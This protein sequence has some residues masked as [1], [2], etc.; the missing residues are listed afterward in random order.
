MFISIIT[1]LFLGSVIGVITSISVYGFISLVKIL[2]NIF[3][4]SE[5]S[6]NGFYGLFEN[7]LEFILFV[8]ITPFLIGLIVGIIRKYASDSR[9][10]GPPDVILAVHSEKKLLD[11]KSGFLTSFS[12]ILS[13]SA[14]GSVGQYGPLVHFGATLGAEINDL[15]KR[16]G[17]YQIYVGAGVAAA[18]SSGFGAPLAGLIFAREVILRHQ[19]LA[20][21]APILVSSIISYLFTKNFFGLEPLFSSK[22]GEIDSI[23]HFPFFII[24]GIM[25]G[26]I[27]ILYMRGLTHPKY[28]PNISKINPILQPALAGLIC[29]LVALYLPQVIG[30]GTQTIKDLVIGNFDL[31][32]AL[33]LLLF[34]LLLTVICLRMGLIG[35][36]FA[37]ALFLG[38]CVGVILGIVFQTF[39]PNLNTSLLTVASMSAFASC[40][41]GGP[42][43]NMM[44]ILELTSDYQAT[45]AAGISI[46]FASLVSYKVIGQSVF[47]KVLA[48]KNIDLDLGRENIKLQ[49][50][51]ISEICHK[52]YCE[53]ASTS[54]IEN[55]IKKMVKSKNSE[56]YLVNS[57]KKIINKLEL[58][59]L[60]SIKN[61][62]QLVTKIKKVSF[63]K[64]YS[65]ENILDSIEKCKTFVGESIPVI[66]KD[67]FLQGVVTEGDLFQ[68]FLKITKEEK[69]MEHEN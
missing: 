14:G 47:D 3:R 26:A 21:F 28:F 42:V 18:I 13:I 22:I 24:S 38:A 8:I 31:E 46:V 2:T 55:A 67:G 51:L 4:N 57:Q 65:T 25:C 16:K 41:I 17:Q 53:V 29:G 7:T 15:F 20:S 9:W 19:S 33:I 36:V 62:K 61:K 43:A 32:F 66:R 40:V 23:N 27:S 49:Q 5:N 68:I 64:L 63:L 52:D 58:P 54:S 50:T 34:K 10:H 39:S 59:F 56:A 44:I 11:I 69:K 48:N 12:S 35:G 45:L 37:P 1:T 30:L 6:F 60:L